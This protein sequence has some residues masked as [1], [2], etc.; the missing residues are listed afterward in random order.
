MI[1]APVLANALFSPSAIRCPTRPPAIPR[2]T[3]PLTSV[4]T[5]VTSRCSRPLKNSSDN[6]EPPA[7]RTVTVKGPSIKHRAPNIAKRKG[8]R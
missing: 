6:R 1:W 4:G 2:Y 8:R 3:S 7:L 5:A